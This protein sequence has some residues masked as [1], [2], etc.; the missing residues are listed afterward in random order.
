MFPYY[1]ELKYK[2]QFSKEHLKNIAYRIFE[3]KDDPTGCTN[4]ELA[5][6]KWKYQPN[7]EKVNGDNNDLALE[8]YPEYFNDRKLAK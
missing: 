3:Q 4:F 5:V 8:K 2:T 6:N 1:A 7:V